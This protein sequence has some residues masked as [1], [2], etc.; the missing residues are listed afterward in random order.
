M[1]FFLEQD[2]FEIL[3]SD[4]AITAIVADRIYPIA[5]PQNI[6]FPA[7]TYQTVSDFQGYNME[8]GDG[9]NQ[10]RIQFDIFSDSYAGGKALQDAVNSALSGY[11]GEAGVQ[12]QGAFQQDTQDL[13][14]TIDGKKR[15]RI[16]LDYVFHYAKI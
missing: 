4:A 6:D 9:L 16:T 8:G 7:L 3:K 14:E 13:E 11:I 10:S 12:I 5:P 15:F 2:V 1:S